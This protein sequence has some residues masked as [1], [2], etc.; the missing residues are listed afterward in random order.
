M[1]SSSYSYDGGFLVLGKQ[2]KNLR[3]SA[4]LTQEELARELNIT[5]GTYAHYELDKREPSYQVLTQL[6]NFFNVSV[7]YL[8][9]QIDTEMYLVGSKIKLIIDTKG[10]RQKD[11][12]LKLNISPS[13]LNGYITGYR[14]P[15]IYTL[16]KIANVLGYP[17]SYFIDFQENPNQKLDKKDKVDIV[18]EIKEIIDRINS[19][20]QDLLY[21]NDQKISNDTKEL[22]R[23]ALEF[24]LKIVKVEKR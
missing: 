17:T 24:A 9:G 5:R 3:K 1:L 15:D 16:N 18:K 21:Y 6:S 10:I 8:L 2:L 13:T 14:T 11:L 7:D 4:N 22:F 12:A 19:D 20:K 23:D